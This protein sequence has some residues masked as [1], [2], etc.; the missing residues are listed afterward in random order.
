MTRPFSFATVRL[1]LGMGLALIFLQSLLDGRFHYFQVKPDASPFAVGLQ[2]LA[3]HN[4]VTWI[5]LLSI[6]M[7]FGL[8]VGLARRW[9]ALWL[10]MAWLAFFDA[11]PIWRDTD[12]IL[13]TWLLLLFVLVPSGEP[14][15]RHWNALPSW[16]VAPLFPFLSTFIFL[17]SQWGLSLVLLQG[18]SALRIDHFW[19]ELAL[20]PGWVQFLANL[21]PKAGLSSLIGWAPGLLFV[22]ALLYF[23]MRTRKWALFGILFFHMARW[24]AGLALFPLGSLLLVWSLWP[25]ASQEKHKIVVF[26]DGVCGI[27]NRFVQF[28]LAEDLSGHIKMA[29]LQGKTAQRKLGERAE[30]LET[31]IVQVDERFLERSDAAL[32]LAKSLGGGWAWFSLLRFLPRGFRDFC[33]KLVAANRYRILKPAETCPIPS[34]E[35]RTR[36]LA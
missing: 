27:C 1:L 36:F 19:T 4:G 14:Q 28:L 2:F 12:R 20:A 15:I 33:Y 5:L 3:E 16:K 29:P 18:E 9:A 21:L 13:V 31:V 24:L 23:P 8:A 25:V 34:P 26:F 30:A 22:V 35:Q 10:W 17:A 6:L 11:T 7:A 32:F